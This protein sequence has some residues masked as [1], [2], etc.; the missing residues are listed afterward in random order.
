MAKQRI[1]IVGGGFGGVKAA[2]ELKHST[3]VSVTLLSDNP[4][5]RYYPTSYHT[6]TGGSRENA[7]MPLK[8]LFE[9][10]NVRLVTGRAL[11]LDRAA[12]SI[13]TEDKQVHF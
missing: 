5:F 3:K 12:K 1:L 8:E 6:A 2:L 9:D 11:T 7:A 10:S 13:T 4:D